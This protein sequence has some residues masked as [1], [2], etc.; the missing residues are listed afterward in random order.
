MHPHVIETGGGAEFLPRRLHRVFCQRLPLIFFRFALAGKNPRAT[1]VTLKAAQHLPRRRI[2]RYCLRFP[3]L[4][5]V[6]QDRS[7]VE[8]DLILRSV[9]TSD[10]RHPV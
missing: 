7:G 2:D 3:G 5:S 1:I 8:I 6:Q 10:K 9:N 4:C